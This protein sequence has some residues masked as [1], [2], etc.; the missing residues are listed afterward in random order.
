MAAPNAYKMHS[1]LVICAYA[2]REGDRKTDVGMSKKT[3]GIVNTPFLGKKMCWVS[4]VTIVLILAVFSLQCAVPES[5]NPGDGITTSSLTPERS[6]GTASLLPL[7]TFDFHLYFKDSLLGETWIDAPITMNVVE[8]H[9]PYTGEL[10]MYMT[11]FMFDWTTAFN[12]FLAPG[13]L[14]IGID[15]YG[16]YWYS[17]NSTGKVRDEWKDGSPSWIGFRKWPFWATRGGEG[18]YAESALPDAMQGAVRFGE[19]LWLNNIR[20]YFQNNVTV[21]CSPNSLLLWADFQWNGT[22]WTVTSQIWDSLSKQTDLGSRNATL[23]VAYPLDP[24]KTIIIIA[25]PS[26]VALIAYR[27]RDALRARMHRR[28]SIGLEGSD[29]CYQQKRWFS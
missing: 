28:R 12:P 1:T 20:L 29:F 5:L 27:K 17:Y 23:S 18:T 16:C 10:D 22:N 21:E 19:Y 11:G 9:D 8:H 2:Y 14:G 24:A 6:Y 13:L 7:P 25:V 4:L 26:L 15:M 3:S